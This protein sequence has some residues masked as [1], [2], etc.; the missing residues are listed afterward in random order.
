[1]QGLSDDDLFALQQRGG[2]RR[3][4]VLGLEQ[5]EENPLVQRASVL[6]ALEHMMTEKL[7]K[8]KRVLPLIH[9]FEQMTP[10]LPV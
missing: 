4:V 7:I 10:D 1:M 9:S 3:V 2:Q 5:R 8:I 6:D